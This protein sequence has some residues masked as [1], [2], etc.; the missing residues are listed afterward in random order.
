MMVCSVKTYV[1]VYNNLCSLRVLD[2]KCVIA[3]Y[4]ICKNI[5]VHRKL[6]WLQHCRENNVLWEINRKTEQQN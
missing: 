5:S 2:V 1:H 4:S 3:D 6:L